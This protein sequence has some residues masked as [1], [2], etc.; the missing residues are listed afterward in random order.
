MNSAEEVVLSFDELSYEVSNFYYKILHCDANWIESDLTSMEYLDGFDGGMIDTYEYSVNTAV[1]YIHYTL[2]LPN[3]NVRLKL[4]GN[5]V[6]KIAREGDFEH[7]VVATACFSISESLVE[8]SAEISG[9]TTKELNGSYQSLVLD[10][11]IKMNSKK[12]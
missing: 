4:S 8:V 1:N 7:G 10:I 2:R 11:M 9:S 5:Y 12:E 3:D 6:V